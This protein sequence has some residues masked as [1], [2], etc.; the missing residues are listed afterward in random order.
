M[1]KANSAAA[2]RTENENDR[3]L[4]I[5]EERLLKSRTILLTDAI[6]KELTERV[7]A[8]LLLLEQE[9]GTE[10]IDLYIN[11]PGGDVDAGFGIFDMVRFISAPTR[12]ISAGLAASAAIIVLVS[13]PRERRLSLP[14]SRFLMH[15]P[16]AGVRGSSADIQIE[17][18]EILKMR[19]KIN[20]L[21]SEE[22]GQPLEKVEKDA[23]RNYWMT[24][25]EARDYGLISR[26][27]RSK[28]EIAG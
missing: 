6:T 4:G 27:V 1:K 17:A 13:V 16:S 9:S 7:T 18:N 24:A 2:A 25:E 11:S 23:R 15:Q 10:P 5:L 21:I 20:S 12:C 8:K 3:K 14:N 28:E 19:A 26:I 22:T